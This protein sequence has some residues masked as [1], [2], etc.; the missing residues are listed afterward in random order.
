M[1]NKK[2]DPEQ[3]PENKN[4]LNG[5]IHNLLGGSFLAKKEATRL[6]PFI[7]Y[8]TLLAIIYIANTYYAEKKV[9]EMDEL[10][11]GL[12]ELRYEYI[13]TK[14]NLMGQTKQSSIEEL[15]KARG[16]KASVTPPKKIVMDD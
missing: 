1:E 14:S 2:K 7:L 5:S 9:R 15:L 13:T 6:L 10:R 3:K 4:G 16:I 8:L 11:N 12:K